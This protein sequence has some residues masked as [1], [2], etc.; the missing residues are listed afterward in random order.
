MQKITS[1]EQL[2]CDLKDLSALI[3]ALDADLSRINHYIH[4]DRFIPEA[5]G[6]K[7]SED[8][9]RI[10]QLQKTIEQ[11]F[12]LL[13]I[14]KLPEETA[15]TEEILAEYQK[16]LEAKEK[17]WAAAAFFLSLHSEDS[18]MEEKLEAK[19][20]EL[21]H[22]DL[23][24]L[25]ESR[26][27][28]LL[29]PYILLKHTYEETDTQKKFMLLYELPKYFDPAIFTGIGTGAI[30]STQ[31]EVCCAQPQGNDI[32]EEEEDLNSQDMETEPAA[33]SLSV[34]STAETHIITDAQEKEET[35]EKEE[36]PLMEDVRTSAPVT[37]EQE[38][39]RL[40][41]SDVIKEQE[42]WSQL[43]IED[44]TAVCHKE[45]PELLRAEM[46]SKAGD[47]FGVS[48]FKS[49][50]TKQA[51]KEK[52]ACL[53]EA[54]N[55]CAYTKESIAIYLNK[56]PGYYDFVTDKL[57]QLGYLKKYSVSGMGEFFTLS[58]RGEKAFS[59]KASFTF[60]QKL[61]WHTEKI[62]ADGKTPIKDST[63]AAV[64]RLLNCSCY[65]RM[66]QLDSQ[67]HFVTRLQ[68]F[69]ENSFLLTFQKV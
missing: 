2:R 68:T 51:L 1:V 31:E 59:T 5:L 45:Q 53:V 36:Q 6:K 20:E 32:Q 15:K 8:L 7:A 54:L 49:D 28:E 69:D 64:I 44:I 65:A 63:N 35:E 27:E 33:E 25:D 30:R 26:L 18:G 41:G 37:D 29:H 48:K 16:K 57:Y 9:N 60:L 17:Y 40:P 11:Q 12:T 52:T 10:D 43:G 66:R 46:S 19:K 38:K 3:T 21:Q 24:S 67:Y 55:G 39:T 61:N 62:D 23:G 58:P 14:G 13:E 34:Q 56:K 22:M 47:K 4:T 50:F 42:L